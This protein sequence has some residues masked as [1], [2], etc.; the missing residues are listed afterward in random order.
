[1]HFVHKL[2]EAVRFRLP[3][4]GGTVSLHVI[5]DAAQ[6]GRLT[7]RGVRAVAG[8]LALV[9]GLIHQLPACA[10][11]AVSGARRSVV[12]EPEAAVAWRRFLVVV[13]RRRCFGCK[14]WGMRMVRAR[15]DRAR[16]V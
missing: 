13:P 1:M 8:L 10:P 15:I 3:C 5:L 7:L 14:K 16:S 11:T 12:V 4:E 6:A 2:R 9:S